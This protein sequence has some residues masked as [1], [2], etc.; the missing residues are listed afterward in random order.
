M[1]VTLESR[2]TELGTLEI[3]CNESRGNRAW[4]LEFDLRAGHGE[5]EHGV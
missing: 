1:A 3:W 2:V 4:K 5:G